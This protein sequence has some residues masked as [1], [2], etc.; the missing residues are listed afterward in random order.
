MWSLVLM[1]IETDLKKFFEPGNDMK[2]FDIE[3]FITVKN[4]S[5][6]IHT[7]SYDTA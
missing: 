5:K 4:N 1:V 2:I 3:A 6:H 7:K